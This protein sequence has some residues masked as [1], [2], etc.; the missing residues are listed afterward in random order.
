M[1]LECGK[2]NHEDMHMLRRC[3]VGQSGRD[4]W[5][6]AAHEWEASVGLRCAWLW[7]WATAQWAGIERNDLQLAL[8][9]RWMCSAE[10]ACEDSERAPEQRLGRG[11]VA[12]IFQQPG[13]VV[14]TDSVV[15]LIGFG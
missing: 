13:Q 6:M 1:C 10:G 5:Y 15:T 7:R 12:L 2:L 8:L 9:G 11:V 4:Q 3:V 14:Q